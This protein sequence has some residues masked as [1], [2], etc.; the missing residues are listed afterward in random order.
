MQCAHQ[1]EHLTSIGKMLISSVILRQLTRH[2]LHGRIMRRS[3]QTMENL[4]L[5]AGMFAHPE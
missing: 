1:A 4:R 5:I 2:P 3:V